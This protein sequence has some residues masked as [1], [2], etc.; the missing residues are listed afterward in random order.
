MADFNPSFEEMILEE[1]GYKLTNIAGDRGGSTYA[2][3]SRKM[4]PQW[5]G[6]AAID[7]GETPPT[8]LVR[9][10]YH[11]GYWAP[12]RGDEITS[13]LIAHSIFSFAVNTSTPGRPTLAVKLAQLC[14][15]VVPDGVIGPKTL[16]ALN[17]ADEGHFRSAYALAKIARYR[18]ICMRD[19]SQVKFLLGWINRSLKGVA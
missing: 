7:R 6:W 9:D 16:R 13:Q 8:Y 11:D 12:I 10:F 2:G 19:R 14:L 1:G 5:P 18:D 3:I 4:N 15:G 17:S